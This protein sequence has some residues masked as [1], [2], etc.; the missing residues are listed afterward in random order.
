MKIHY[1]EEIRQEIECMGEGG[2]QVHILL[3][4]QIIRI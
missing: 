1:R 2:R 3:D 4:G